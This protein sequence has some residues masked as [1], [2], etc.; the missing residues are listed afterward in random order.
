MHIARADGTGLTQVTGD[1]AV[2]RLPRW[3]PDGKWLVFFSNRSGR[4]QLWKISRDGSELQQLT[5]E[6]GAYPTVSPDGTRVATVSNLDGPSGADGV[7]VFD[8]NRPWKTQKPEKLPP[9]RDPPGA[10]VVNSWSPDS[11]RLAGQLNVTGSGIVTYSFATRTY[12][13]LTDSW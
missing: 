1:S 11:Q 9:M 8:P 12:E 3:F 13:R 2:D 6:G 7:W 5:E 10:F 4:L